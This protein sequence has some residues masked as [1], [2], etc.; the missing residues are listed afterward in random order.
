MKLSDESNTPMT[1]VT[2]AEVPG[3]CVKTPAPRSTANARE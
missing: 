3:E 1:A 2:Q